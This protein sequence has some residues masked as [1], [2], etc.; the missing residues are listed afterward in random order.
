[1]NETATSVQA[2]VPPHCSEAVV[3]FD[4]G[5]GLREKLLLAALR[6]RADKERYSPCSTTASKWP[7]WGRCHL[8]ASTRTTTPTITKGRLS[9]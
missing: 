7:T 2:G 3:L 8:W 1:M 6:Q 9:I 4:G 5:N